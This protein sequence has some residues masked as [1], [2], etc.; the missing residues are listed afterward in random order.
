MLP[1]LCPLL[2][3]VSLCNYDRVGGLGPGFFRVCLY[4]CTEHY[5]RSLCC[6]LAY[7]PGA[8]GYSCGVGPGRCGRTVVCSSLACIIVSL[9]IAAA[10]R[11]LA[12]RLQ[13][14][15]RVHDQYMSPCCLARLQLWSWGKAMFLCLWCPACLYVIDI[16]AVT[17]PCLCVYVLFGAFC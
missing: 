14:V 11:L 5:M 4:M 10:A 6:H 16:F 3:A 8:A 7:I 2:F 12:V 9:L 13:V 15:C 17:G 1:K